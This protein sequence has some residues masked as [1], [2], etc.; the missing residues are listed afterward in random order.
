M[1]LLALIALLGFYSPPATQEDLEEWTQEHCTSYS[2]QDLNSGII[3][4]GDPAYVECKYSG[5]LDP[6]VQVFATSARLEIKERDPS[7]VI[8]GLHQADNIRVY[9]TFQGPAGQPGGTFFVYRLVRQ[10]P[11]DQQFQSRRK[12]LPAGDVDALLELGDW[13]SDRYKT[14]PRRSSAMWGKALEMYQEATNILEKQAGADDFEAHLR[15]ARILLNRVED[16]PKTLSKLTETCL[17]LRPDDSDL[18]AFLLEDLGANL[19]R[20]KWIL[21]EDF[22]RA[23]GFILRQDDQ[24]WIPEPIALLESF[25]EEVHKGAIHME[26]RLGQAVYEEPARKG[27]IQRGMNKYY[28]II[29]ISYPDETLRLLSDDAEVLEI[30]I[31]PKRYL[32]FRK[33]TLAKAPIPR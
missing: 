31:Y 33:G 5:Y 29:A 17:K 12:D 27:Q 25:A 19:Y 28:V 15:I 20:G 30:W 21:Y 10:P 2:I 3:P 8:I 13:A 11:D 23:E 14:Y 22:K 7:R 24:I 6:R 9:G 1:N 18:H 16:R 26:G 32:L 4:I